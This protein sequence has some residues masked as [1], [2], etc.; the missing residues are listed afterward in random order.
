MYLRNFNTFLLLIYSVII[1]NRKVLDIWFLVRSIETQREDKI[2]MDHLLSNRDLDELH[3]E[4]AY[5]YIEIVG[6]DC[7]DQLPTE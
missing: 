2:I 7:N 4:Y 5:Y 6:N 1:S 3:V